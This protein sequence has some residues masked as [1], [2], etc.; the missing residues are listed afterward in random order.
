MKTDMKF[1]RKKA[2]KDMLGDLHRMARKHSV[3]TLASKVGPSET[4]DRK[5]VPG[6]PDLDLPGGAE[7]SGGTPESAHAEDVDSLVNNE[8]PDLEGLK[9]LL[10]RMGG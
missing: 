3:T 5:E 1:D 2:K 10:S 6:T 4:K 7:Y 9:K 8:T